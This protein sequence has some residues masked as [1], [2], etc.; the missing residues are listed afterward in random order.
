MAGPDRRASADMTSELKLDLLK[1]GY[2]FSFFQATRL[3]HLLSMTSAAEKSGHDSG[4][5]PVWT[6]PNL[7]LA[8][9]KADVEAIHEKSD[10]RGARFQMLV[11]FLGLYGTSSPLPVFYTE[12]LID[13]AADDESAAREFIDIINQRLYQLFY[14]CSTKYHQAFKIVEQG[15]DHYAERLFCLLG[16]GHPGLRAQIPGAACLVRYL[17]L[18]TQKPRSAL[19]LETILKDVLGGMTVA[20]IPCIERRA[21]IPEDQ[22]LTL[23]SAAHRLGSNCF[24]GEQITDRMGKFRVRIGPLDNREF[25]T[26]YPGSESYN[27]VALLVNMYVLDALEYDLEV[28][29]A[30]GQAKTACLGDAARSELGLNTWVF[31][32]R[33]VGEVRT[34]YRPEISASR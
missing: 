4:R 20:V 8:F 2:S 3:L 18:F 10:A 12:D 22:K 23:G 25:S 26:F 27:R 17:G 5:I 15:S 14:D 34:Y 16:I 6:R 21:K 28:I 13:E 11:N 24:L 7:S 1:E 30:Q 33:K 29:L 32:G 19:G 9:P 31:S